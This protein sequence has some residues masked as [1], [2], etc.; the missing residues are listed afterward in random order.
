MIKVAGEGRPRFSYRAAQTKHD[1]CFHACKSDVRVW[2][3]LIHFDDKA[4]TIDGSITRR[5]LQRTA[6]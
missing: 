4:C 1:E 6:P 5:I 3:S 2:K